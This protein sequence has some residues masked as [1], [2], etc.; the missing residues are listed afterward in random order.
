M[1]RIRVGLC[2][3][4]LASLFGTSVIATTVHADFQPAASDAVQATSNV[5]LPLVIQTDDPVSVAAR[6]T[7]IWPR[8]SPTPTRTSTPSKTPIATATAS[9]SPLPTATASLPPT[10]TQPPPP[11]SVTGDVLAVDTFTAPDNTDIRQH[12]TDNG[13]SWAIHQGT[14]T[15][16]K[17]AAQNPNAPAYASVEVGT[18]NVL[19][20][21]DITTPDQTPESGEEWFV[22]FYAAARFSGIWIESGVEL[23]ML[24]QNHSGE[25]EIWE[26]HQ[27]KSY[28]ANPNVNFNF[29]NVTVPNAANP[30]QPFQPGK[31][32]HVA[33]QLYGDTAVAYY[34]GI[35]T[36]MMQLGRPVGTD[37]DLN[38]TG[39][40][41][42][43]SVDNGMPGSR[44]DNLRIT[45]LASAPPP[46][47]VPVCGDGNCTGGQSCN[48]CG[49]CLPPQ[50]SKTCDFSDY[51]PTVPTYI[52]MVTF[53]PGP[54]AT[55]GPTNTPAAP[56]S[57]TH[58]ATP[59][60]TATTPPGGETAGVPQYAVDFNQNVETWWSEHPFNPE[61]P[62]YVPVGGIEN[63]AGLPELNVR[64]Q[65]G[66][67]LQAA[68]D[69]LPATGGTLV[70]DAG[71]YSA[72]NLVGKN[73]I[74][75]ISGGGAVIGGSSEVAPISQALDYG[76]FNSCSFY[77]DPVCIAALQN[78]TSNIYFKNITFDGGGTAMSAIDLHA[79]RGVV[80][81]NV[82]FQ[83]YANPHSG[84][85]GLINGNSTLNNVW[86]RGCRFA[87]SQR[88]A[89]YLDGAH[90]SGILDSTIE[91]NFDN[92]LLFLTNDD[93]TLDINR[94]GE[95]DASERR[96]GNYIVVSGNTFEGNNIYSVVQATAANM[97]IRNNTVLGSLTYFASF[98]IRNS[99]RGIVY[100][101]YGTRLVGNHTRNLTY[102]S[103]WGGTLAC[104]PSAGQTCARM[105]QYELRDNVIQN[106]G[107]YRDLALHDPSTLTQMDGPY[108]TANNCVNG[109]VEETGAACSGT[110]ATATPRPPVPTQTPLP[111][112][113]AT[114]TLPAAPTTTP[115]PTAVGDP[116]AFPLGVFE[117]GNFQ[118]SSTFGGMIDD[119]RAHNLNS[120]FFVNTWSSGGDMLNVSDNKDFDVYYN[121]NEGWEA[122]FNNPTAPVDIATARSTFYPLIDAV[123]DHPSLKGYNVLDEPTNDLQSKV[124][125][126][127]Q[128]Y[129]ER[130]PD[131]LTMPTLIG[132]GRADPICTASQPDV[133]MLDVYPFS[134]D[135]AACDTTMRAFGYPTYDFVD[136]VRE[137]VQSK[138]AGAPLWVIL[139][140]HSFGDGSES[141]HLRA[142]TAPELREEQWLAIGEGATG[143]F[144]FIYS[145]EQ[146]W[147]GLQDNPALFSEV[148]SL[149]QR[150]KPLR[151]L[152][153]T[154]SKTTDQFAVS[155]SA[156]PAYASTL[157][158]DAGS[159]TYVVAVNKQCA[160]QDLTLSSISGQKQLRDLETG[161]IYSTGSAL[162]FQAGDGRIFEVMPG[163]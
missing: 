76:T 107:S 115:V 65:Y 120:V 49:A 106:A 42:A 81:D 41:V 142:P 148:S 95:L 89:I 97:L 11:T 20:E 155:G 123:K 113:T 55:P 63:F 47:G 162:P 140:T 110:A 12:Q 83:N 77:G 19:V 30:N 160:A 99:N 103:E 129:Q 91:N 137:I 66:S 122:W 127:V 18:G 62:A 25:Y 60:V 2:F 94:N 146:G 138:P 124:A 78:Q 15:I 87:G 159:Q 156:G 59:V 68:V 116:A 43:I 21:A 14:W 152:L 9:P 37:P 109:Y 133:M 7:K 131:R 57:P 139:Q 79:V 8:K 61:S 143:V 31:T 39:T 121:L 88:Y 16:I 28:L 105:G 48:N 5:W 23:R 136:Y 108:V 111:E 40:R 135:N 35:P 119:L 86:C 54:T 150:I 46:P 50:S 24:Y 132:I 10:A 70:L 141:W 6:P 34:N 98:D 33:L 92:G 144:W 69:A 44:I 51:P 26:W 100:N 22:G 104:N 27:G 93:F 38:Q 3:V 153:V 56:V 118:N 125:L 84:H 151:S 75:F 163:F 85:G 4:L 112:P 45:R 161:Q 134:A 13:L 53:T 157:T 117:D 126:A 102:L 1:Q 73:N 154:L 90:G 80:F 145:S 58:T 149:A 29:V 17:G 71:T 32:H 158:N 147:T 101:F 74:H 114:P 36:V 130:D 64:Q 52:P 128:A 72:F 67:N 82:T 96:L